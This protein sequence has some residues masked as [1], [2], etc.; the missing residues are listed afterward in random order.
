MERDDPLDCGALARCPRFL[1]I[2]GAALG[3]GWL[4]RRVTPCTG[5]MTGH[6]AMMRGRA[7]ENPQP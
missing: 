6:T 5:L 4:V 7:D 1:L 2:G 3:A